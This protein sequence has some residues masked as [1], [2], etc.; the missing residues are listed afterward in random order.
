MF[1][2]FVPVL[3]VVLALVP[4]SHAADPKP[5]EP[6]NGKDLKGWK[7]KDEKSNK[8]EVL[9]LGAVDLD[10]KNPSQFVHTGASNT[11]IKD[12]L[13]VNMKSGTD[14]YT[15][16]E[17]GDIALELEFMVPKG[18]NSGI[19]LMGEYEVQILDSYGKPDDKLTQGDLGSL[20]STA[21]P[22]KNVAKKPG[23]WQKFVI[24]FRAPKFEGD[25]K[26]ANAKFVKV[27][28]N[29]TVL[30]ENVEVKQQTPGGLTGKERATGPVMFQGDHGPV[31]FRNIK[32]T[33]K[34]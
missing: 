29:D 9:A 27:T 28:L 5:I 18:S 11:L 34:K 23:E 13:L 26:T 33:P 21:A 19:Y 6:F 14:I 22:K 30:H 2:A 17:F 25:K 3:A 16:A 10:S 4:G 15:E 20:Y 8:W 24:E 12:V 1:R 7:L 31:A 32:I